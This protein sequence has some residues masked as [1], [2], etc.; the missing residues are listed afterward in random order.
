[1]LGWRVE[2]G[3]GGWKERV[4]GGG[5]RGGGRGRE[6]KINVPIDM[7]MYNI[8]QVLLPPPPHLLFLP[9]YMYM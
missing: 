9:N 4:E 1:M 8:Y 3:G 7:Y 2:G 5:W 6:H